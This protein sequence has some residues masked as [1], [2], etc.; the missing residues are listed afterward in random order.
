[1]IKYVETSN[2][3]VVYREGRRPCVI[4][5]TSE[6]FSRV[7]SLLDLNDEDRLKEV[8]DL[9]GI[10][11]YFGIL[12]EKSII[13]KQIALK[14]LEGTNLSSEEKQ[15]LSTTYSES[16]NCGPPIPTGWYAH[17]FYNSLEDINEQDYVI[18]DVHTAP[19][20]AIGN[21]VGW[22]FHVGTGPINMAVVLAPNT[23]GK[24]VAFCGPVMSYYEHTSVNFKRLTDEE[25]ED[26]YS[27]PM[28]LRPEWVNLYL[29]R[30]DGNTESENPPSLPTGL[31]EPINLMEKEIVYSAYPNPFLTNTLIIAQIP[32]NL[33][34]KQF[35]LRIFGINSIF[36]K[37]LFS[38]QLSSGNF[39]FRRDGKDYN[40]NNTYSGVYKFEL[41]CKAIG[42][43]TVL[44]RYI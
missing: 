39:S 41:D 38:G 2:Y 7:K 11:E 28:S 43:K 18:A 26:L 23:N 36:V 42:D 17:L 33:N 27:D 29:A 9:I 3:L 16:P 35:K 8:F 25:W 37:E 40:G 10:K 19:T 32:E 44:I 4:E 21:I 14:E 1:M 5:K 31:D 20:D 34:G 13:L 6:E 22:V 15:F 12:A 24:M 30:K